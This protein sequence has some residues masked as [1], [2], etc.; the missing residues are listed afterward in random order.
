MKSLRLLPF[1]LLAVTGCTSLPPAAP[2]KLTTLPDRVRVEINGQLF[3][4]YIHGDGASRPYSYPILLGDGTAF[5]R[6]FP[7]KETAGEESDHPHHRAL[8]F[9]HGDANKIDM[10]NEGKA[11]GNL[12]KGRTVHAGGLTTSDGRVGVITTRNRWQSPDGKLIATDDTTMRFR[13]AGGGNRFLDYEVTIHALPDTPLVL[14]DSK[15][16]TM[17]IRL[18]QWL[19]LPHKVKGQLVPGNG[20]YLTSTGVRDAAAWGTRADWCDAYAERDGKTYGVAIFD[21]PQNLRHPTWWMARD[22]GLFNANPFGQS[23]FEP[24]KKL[25]K[26]AGDYTIPAGGSLTLRYR[27]YFHAGDPAAAQV[28]A[29][30]ADYAAGR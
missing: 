4:E 19:V 8:M 17:S 26:N 22:Y 11:G 21:H 18:A 16:G 9:A 15:E 29:R 28:A 23:E 24:E 14:G 2:V 12:P 7:M 13:D 25:P 6:D 3:T 27:F 10:W 20:H 5:T 30:Y 1:A